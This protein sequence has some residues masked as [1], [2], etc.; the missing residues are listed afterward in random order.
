[1]GSFR[2]HLEVLYARNGTVVMGVLNVTPDS[3]FDGGRWLGEAGMRQADELIAEGA[4]IL[5]IGGESTRP[6]ARRVSA[7]QQLERIEPI[8]KYVL[9]HHDVL[10]TVD[11]TNAEVADFALKAGAHAI[12]DVSCLADPELASVVAAHAAGLI[13]MHSRGDMSQMP[14]FS[15]ISED[16]YAD[17][18]TEVK[19][20]WRRAREVAIARGVAAEDIAFDPGVGFWKSTLHSISVLQRVEEFSDLEAPIII[21]P[22]RKSFLNVFGSISP[23]KRLGG[24]L[25]ACLYAAEKGVH[26]VRVHDV[27]ATRQALDFMHLFRQR[28]VSSR[29]QRESRIVG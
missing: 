8:L 20:E 4:A 19:C 27:L 21:G 11:T 7:G 25:A 22:S 6:T 29:V 16:A 14:G 18:V 28:S 9:S 12:N 23:E 3:F 15:Q 17:V 26:A 1:V 24:S 13:L 10:V 5:D 2:S